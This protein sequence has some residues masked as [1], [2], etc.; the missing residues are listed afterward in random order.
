MGLGTSGALVP[1]EVVV[2]RKWGSHGDG[3]P[4]S[5]Q[6]VGRAIILR[7]VLFGSK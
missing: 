4:G 5:Q 2:K 7:T 1:R 6:A 3:S